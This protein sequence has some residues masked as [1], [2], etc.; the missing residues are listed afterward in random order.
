VQV[1]NLIAQFHSNT[2]DSWGRISFGSQLKRANT[3]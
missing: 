2:K 3:D 1:D